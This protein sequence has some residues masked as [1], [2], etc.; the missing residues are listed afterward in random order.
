MVCPR[1]KSCDPPP[2]GL[3]CPSLQIFVVTRQRTEEHTLAWHLGC[4]W[5]RFNLTET[6][7][8]QRRPSAAGAQLS[9]APAIEAEC[10]ENPAQRKV[11]RAGNRGSEKLTQQKAQAAQPQIPADLRL[12]LEVLCPMAGGTSLTITIS[13]FLFPQTPCEQVGGS[14]CNWGTLER[15]LFSM[16]QSHYLLGPRNGYP[17]R[18]G[19]FCPYSL[20]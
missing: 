7:S 15:L 17:S 19:F 13:H 10:K 1:P 16:S 11:L 14:G 20:C 12:R 5:L 3:Q 6:T 18:W 8:T 2:R 4:L 9:E